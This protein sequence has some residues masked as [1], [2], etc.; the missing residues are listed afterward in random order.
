MSHGHESAQV[1][2]RGAWRVRDSEM[3]R[4]I[5]MAAEEF[6]VDASEPF[7]ARNMASQLRV[8]GTAGLAESRCAKWRARCHPPTL[9][10]RHGMLSVAFGSQTL[11]AP[12]AR[13]Q[14]VQAN[15]WKI[16]VDRCQAAGACLVCLL[17]PRI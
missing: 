4:T 8:F 14:V 2:K 7:S 6:C 5:V 15:E 17:P 1:Y 13:R 16:L 3:P 10:C 11:Y 9:Q 12:V